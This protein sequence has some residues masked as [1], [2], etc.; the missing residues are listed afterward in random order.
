MRQIKI[1][2][3]IVVA[4]TGLAGENVYAQLHVPKVDPDRV[5]SPHP[6]QDFPNT[7]Y[8]GDTHLH[9]SSSV[10][11]GM[12]GNTV[13]PEDAYRFALGEEVRSSTGLRARLKRPLDFL[14]ISDHAENLGMA[15][16]IEK[17][18]QV[19]LDNP[20]AKRYHDMVKS[21]QG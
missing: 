12:A 7:V 4:T 13:G 8:F 16:L 2:S 20:Q 21:G 14:V 1:L 18:A 5:C 11:A 17:S 19:V 15:P 10:D 6:D 9:T 3:L